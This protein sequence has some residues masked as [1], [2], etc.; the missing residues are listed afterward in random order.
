MTL[1][2]RRRFEEQLH[3]M[4]LAELEAELG[5]WRQDSERNGI[6]FATLAKR[7]V[8]AR[9]KAD[10]TEQ[11]R[12][13]RH[14][15]QLI[16][17]TLIAAVIGALI[18]AAATSWFS[19]RSQAKG[20]LQPAPL[21]AATP[22]QSPT[23]TSAVAISSPT[24]EESQPTEEAATSEESPQTEE[25]PTPEELVPAPEEL[26]PAPEESVPTPIPQEP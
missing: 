21:A 25:P 23:E 6:V 1:D 14:L 16:W 3:R 2:Q 17:C 12:T 19:S 24:L 15:R 9:A 10:A 7:R 20:V 5:K 8:D 22:A 11:K 13:E 18:G 4:P 26:V